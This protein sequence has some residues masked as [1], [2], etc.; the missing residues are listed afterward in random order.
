MPEIDFD[1]AL[2]PLEPK[3][4]ARMLLRGVKVNSPKD[5]VLIGVHAGELNRK[6]QALSDKLAAKHAAELA[7]ADPAARRAL[8][9]HIFA[10]LWA[11]A[12]LTGW[13]NVCSADG[14]AA[15]FE[16]EICRVFLIALQQKRP[17][18][19]KSQGAIEI[20]FGHAPNF[21]DGY[22]PPDLESLGEG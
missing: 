11:R 3:N 21:A 2:A 16:P 22:A 12:V 13:E 17:D 18:I 5:V 14:T 15:A 7:S 6:L 1:A 20:F 8:L 10:E 9:N 4:T 19:A